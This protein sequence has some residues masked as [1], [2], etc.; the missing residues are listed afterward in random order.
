MRRTLSC[1]LI[2]GAPTLALGCGEQPFMEHVEARSADGTVTPFGF[3]CGPV[4]PG[5]S[6]GSGGFDLGADGPGFSV[7]T[8]H[9]R[10]GVEVTIELHD[11]LVASEFYSVDFLESGEVDHIEVETSDGTLFCFNY[12][13]GGCDIASVPACGSGTGLPPSDGE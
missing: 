9:A 11:E 5:S 1:A 4:S 13:G 12:G 8:E 6:A 10:D 2:F 3:A 7:V